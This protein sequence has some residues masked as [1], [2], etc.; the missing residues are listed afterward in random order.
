MGRRSRYAQGMHQEVKERD[1]DVVS[2]ICQRLA[3]RVGAERFRLWFA[4]GVRLRKISD[5]LYV[6]AADRFK[7]DRVRKFRDEI[8]GVA[9]EVTA[10]N[11][12]VRFEIVPEL[13]AAAAER[14]GGVGGE[15]AAAARRRSAKTTGSRRTTR[16]GGRASSAESAAAAS[17]SE[18]QPFS[19]MVEGD[20]NRLA[21]TAAHKVLHRLGRTSPL[22]LHGP[23][24]SGK[25]LLLD[26]IKSAI[27]ATSR[28]RVVSLAAEQFTADFLEALH[29]GGLPSFR[30]KY[31]DVEVLLID[32]VQFFRGKRATLV[33]LQHTLDSLHRGGRQIVL[34][35]DRPPAELNGLGRELTNRMSGGLICAIDPPDYEL[36]LKI[37]TRL[38]KD[39]DVAFPRAVLELLAERLT[40]DVRQLSGALNRLEA[41]SEALKCPITVDLAGRA[42]EDVFRSTRPV[43]RLED[44][45]RA[46]CEVF[47]LESK[48]LQSG[49][50]ARAVSHPRMLAMFLARKHT[51]SAL[52]EIGHY[53]GHRTHST[54]ISA[55]KKVHGW[56]DQRAALQMSYGECSVEDAIRRV[57]A[58]LGAG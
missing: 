18:A 51:R 35:G 43:V 41:T 53:F 26:C 33:E 58:L 12:A 9:A 25:T 27:R 23:S 11:M 16:G 2:A 7:L 3:E 32:D 42:L 44:I 13:A 56:M 39:Y 19:R 31:R 21:L 20:G 55:Q 49:R 6:E 4:A 10:R 28:R 29:G 52:S 5:T 54:V 30:R 1:R 40:G 17:A 37:L 36:R 24:G 22:F 48:S 46:V 8:R 34:A 14:G 38:S 15:Q 45:N 47:G 57:E 50:K